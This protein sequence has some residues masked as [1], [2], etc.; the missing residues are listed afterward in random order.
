MRHLFC[1]N[2]FRQSC[3]NAFENLVRQGDGVNHTAGPH[4]VKAALLQALGLKTL[5]ADRGIDVRIGR[6]FDGETAGPLA[7]GAVLWAKFS[8]SSPLLLCHKGLTLQ[9]RGSHSCAHPA[10]PPISFVT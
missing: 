3:L 2:R 7:G 1:A 10:V 9:T 4:M 6:N 5:F 8:D